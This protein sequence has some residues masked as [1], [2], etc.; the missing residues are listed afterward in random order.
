MPDRLSRIFPLLPEGQIAAEAA[1]YRISREAMTTLVAI[2]RVLRSMTADD[3]DLFGYALAG[4]AALI[5]VYGREG[6][7]LRVPDTLILAPM[8]RPARTDGAEVVRLA[9]TALP[10]GQAVP[11]EADTGRWSLRFMSGQSPAEL[12]V[13]IDPIAVSMP[14]PSEATIA[15]RSGPGWLADRRMAYRSWVG[16]PITLPV[17][18]AEE[19]LSRLVRDL[20]SISQSRVR[21]DAA[22]RVDDLRLWL[23][24]YPDAVPA[25]LRGPVRAR[26]LAAR[27]GGD[28]AAVLDQIAALATS[29]VISAASPAGLG[30]GMTPEAE[31]PDE[32]ACRSFSAAA[33]AA[34]SGMRTGQAQ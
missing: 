8:A 10:R 16:T 25:A 7:L 4:P 3:R 17:A 21:R 15:A 19:V 12:S 28:A 30:S 27:T 1:S 2:D 5:G 29:A 31:R 11:D 9:A 34:L 22:A 24:L 23:R 18:S 13:R 32:A 26:F 14:L 33:R 20:A 6:A